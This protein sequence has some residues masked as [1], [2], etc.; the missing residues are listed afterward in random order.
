MGTR[1]A[2]ITIKQS[3]TPETYAVDMSFTSKTY[4]RSTLSSNEVTYEER[5]RRNNDIDVDKYQGL[6]KMSIQDVD[7]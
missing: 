4:A 3:C 7:I 2:V 1:A 6:W 5:G